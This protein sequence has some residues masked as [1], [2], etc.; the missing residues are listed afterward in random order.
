MHCMILHKQEEF[1]RRE[2][3]IAE[4]NAES[5]LTYEEYLPEPQKHAGMQDGPLYYYHV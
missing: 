4:K 5:T 1:K 3:V 2:T